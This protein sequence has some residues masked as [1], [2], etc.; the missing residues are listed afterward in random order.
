MTRRLLKSIH[1][2]EKLYGLTLKGKIDW[3]YYRTYK[4]NLNK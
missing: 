3:D 4:N 1:I 2:K